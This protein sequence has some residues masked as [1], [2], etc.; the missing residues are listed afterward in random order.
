MVVRGER[1]VLS[2]NIIHNSQ[3]FPYESKILLLFF[4]S[5]SLAIVAKTATD[6]VVRYT[7]PGLP[8]PNQRKKE[9]RKENRNE[10]KTSNHPLQGKE[11]VCTRREEKR[12]ERRKEKK[13]KK[14]HE[15]L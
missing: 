5:S 14:K 7:P 10:K 3:R 9:K 6:L 13:R 1:R 8:H 4:H 11:E 15:K 12:R 2:N